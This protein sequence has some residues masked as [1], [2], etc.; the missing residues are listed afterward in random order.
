MPP[1][2]TAVTPLLPAGQDLASALRFYTEHLGFAVVWHAGSMAGIRRGNVALNLIEKTT[3][4]WIENASLSIGVDDLD[5]LY[6]E[7]QSAAGARVGPL[8]MKIWGRREFHLIDPVGVCFQFYQ[9]VN[10]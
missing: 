7:Y 4:D 1:S 6:R 3:K 2:L 5:A 10:V 8:E 9:Q